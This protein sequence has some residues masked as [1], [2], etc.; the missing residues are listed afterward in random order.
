MS[1]NLI[2]TLEIS[3]QLNISRS[4]A[5]YRCRKLGFGNKNGTPIL[6]DEDQLVMVIDYNK[7]RVKNRGIRGKYDKRN[8]LIVEYFISMRNN[9]IP[10]IANTL[11]IK[12]SSVHSAINQFL[13]DGCVTVKSKLCI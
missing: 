12:E 10:E 7:N 9:S 13:K 6:I 3:R 2:G 4:Q 1:K 11:G 8:I 5:S